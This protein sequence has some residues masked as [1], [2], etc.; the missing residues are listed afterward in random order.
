[1]TP[2]LRS[3]YSLM[4]PRSTCFDLAQ[5]VEVDALGVIHVA[6]GVGAGHD[7]ATKLLGLLDG[8]LRDVAG[9]RDHD[10]LAVDG[11]AL[12]PSAC[13]GGK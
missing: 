9:A 7:L 11:V 3:A 4:R 12:S 6:V 2:A 13:P 5:Q 10:G 1:M 8:V